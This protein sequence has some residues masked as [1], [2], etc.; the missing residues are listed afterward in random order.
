MKSRQ[1]LLFSKKEWSRHDALLFS[2]SFLFQYKKVFIILQAEEK[3]RLI[4]AKNC[5]QMNILG[6]KVTD[7]S[8]VNSTQPLLRMLSTKITVSIQVIDN[9]SITTSKLRDEE[10]W[11]LIS[12]L[13]EKYVLV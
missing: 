8:Q 9:I 4:L 10:L 12:D 6:E 3:L 11:P 7:D 1:A 13:I 2:F 5:G